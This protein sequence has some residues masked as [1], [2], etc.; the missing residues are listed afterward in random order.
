MERK[1]QSAVKYVVNNLITTHR[2]AVINQK[3][4]DIFL[5]P[6]INPIVETPEYESIVDIHLKLNL[7]ATSVQS[8]IGCG[9]LGPLFLT[10]LPAVYATLYDITFVPPVNPGPEPNI[11]S[12]A[13][14]ATIADLRYHHTLATE[15][16]TEYENTD[17]ALHQLLLVSTDKLYV[18]YLCHK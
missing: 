3:N 17:K 16:F 4:V 5:F 12:G 8:N 18:R 11:L 13:T 1:Y 9:T 6:T 14:G 15:I 2:D 10:V 7:N